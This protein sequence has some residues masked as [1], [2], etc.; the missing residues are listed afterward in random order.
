MPNIVAYWLGEASLYLTK[1]E[2]TCS[3]W[4]LIKGHL[5]F[6]EN[7]KQPKQKKN[8]KGF[9]SSIGPNSWMSVLF[10]GKNLTL[11]LCSCIY[12]S[13]KAESCALNSK[14][15]K[16]K[17]Q[18]LFWWRKRFSLWERLGFCIML[19]F[20]PSNHR[21]SNKNTHLLC[22]QKLCTFPVFLHIEENWLPIYKSEDIVYRNTSLGII[23]SAKRELAWSRLVVSA[24]TPKSSG[25][26]LQLPEF[27]QAH[28]SVKDTT[29]IGIW[30]SL[31]KIFASGCNHCMWVFTN[32]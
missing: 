9:T 15:W 14:S 16:M 28:Q 25:L 32:L 2:T 18:K 20:L 24:P 17:P 23:P 13:L 1:S 12:L 10:V 30:W 11:T 6:I 4:K 29:L 26:L 7:I 3:K 19:I 5:N 8:C 31:I 27:H 22:Q 21:G